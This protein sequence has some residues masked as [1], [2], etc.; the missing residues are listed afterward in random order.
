ML[1][2]LTGV[3]TVRCKVRVLNI[4]SSAKMLSRDGGLQ[5]LRNRLLLESRTEGEG[6][7]Q[8]TT[9]IFDNVGCRCGL[10]TNKL[11]QAVTNLRGVVSV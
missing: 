3:C 7:G 5:E 10:V 6:G 4:N 1:Q 8:S 9:G 11:L 2:L